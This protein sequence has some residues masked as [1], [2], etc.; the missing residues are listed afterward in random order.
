[1]NGQ[2]KRGSFV[3]AMTNILVGVVIAFV[4]QLI[5]F[6]HYGYSITWETN[7][8]MTLWFTGVSLARSFILRR[9]FNRITY[10]HEKNHRTIFSDRRDEYVHIPVFGQDRYYD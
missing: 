4:S 2:T 8:W 1:M 3:E 9:I 10:K 7:A 5:I 6:K